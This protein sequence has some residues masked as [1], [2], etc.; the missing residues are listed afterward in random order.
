MIVPRK[1]TRTLKQDWMKT[2]PGKNLP[3]AEHVLIPGTSTLNGFTQC[4]NCP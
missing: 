2:V 1:W 4:A 3:L